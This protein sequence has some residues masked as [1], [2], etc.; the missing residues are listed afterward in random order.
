MEITN[1]DVAL[2]EEDLRKKITNSIYV[3]E[4]EQ[5][6][7]NYKTFTNVIQQLL[8]N[9]QDD[10]TLEQKVNRYKGKIPE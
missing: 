9:K 1:K 2:T 6:V 3:S 10:E 4:P 5:A 7:A 8:L